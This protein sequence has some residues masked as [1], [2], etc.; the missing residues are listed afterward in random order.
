MVGSIASRPADWAGRRRLTP[1]LDPPLAE[2]V[3]LWLE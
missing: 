3:L 1:R 2:S